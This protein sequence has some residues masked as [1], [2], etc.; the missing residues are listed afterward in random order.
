VRSWL[1]RAIRRAAGQEGFTLIEL[2]VA[3]VLGLLVI[4]IAAT[5]FSAASRSQPGLQERDDAISQARFTMERLI[6]EVR[7]GSTVYAAT[8]AQLSL[9]TYVDAASCG[10]ARATT[11]MVCRVTYTCTATDCSRVEANPDGSNPGSPVTVVSGLSSGNVFDYSPSTV[12]PKYIGATFTF[13]GQ[14]GSD[15]ITL[16]DGA[17]LRNPAASPS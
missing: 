3:T 16:S 4:G 13:P 7:Q 10:G 11:A 6:R 17:A 9:A 12:A 1:H 8:P 5:V 15:A 14:N 2:L